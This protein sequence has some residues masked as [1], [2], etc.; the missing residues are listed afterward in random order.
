MSKAKSNNEK[1]ED[2]IRTR[3]ILSHY[4]DAIKHSNNYVKYA[5]CLENPNIWYVLLHNLK[6]NED[7]F[8][9]G[10]YLVRVY[11]HNGEGKT[12]TQDP[13]KNI[14]RF[15]F[16]TPNGIFE[17]EKKCCINIGEFHSH[18]AAKPNSVST[19]EFITNL[20]AAMLQHK[21]LGGG[22][23]LVNSK[24]STE[25]R[26]FMAKESR[27]YNI[28]NYP[29]IMNI[30]NKQYKEYSLKFIQ[31][32]VK[33]SPIKRI[34]E[35]LTMFIEGKEGAKLAFNPTDDYDELNSEQLKKEKQD[36]YDSS[37]EISEKEKI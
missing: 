9:G 31:P 20:V 19:G 23:H 15:I 3:S 28:K 13:T 32:G 34:D 16:L 4:V 30:I 12:W 5:I 1:S 27:D 25:N 6:G 14:P 22:I 35:L 18:N 2:G 24:Y 33:T 8:E 29:G 36:I 11:I 21:E 17:I 26:K 10:E 7:E 37:L